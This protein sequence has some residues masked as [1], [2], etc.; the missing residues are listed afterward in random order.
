MFQ[1]K[2]KLAYNEKIGKKCRNV[3]DSIKMCK[4]HLWL[5]I[6]SLCLRVVSQG[7]RVMSRR[8]SMV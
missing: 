7:G 8:K 5:I 2:E 6:R 1:I 4:I 3:K